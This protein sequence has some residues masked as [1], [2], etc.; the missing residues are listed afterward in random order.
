MLYYL[1]ISMGLGLIPK[2][3]VEM[4]T[5]LDHFGKAN[6]NHSVIK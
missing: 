5:V 3:R 6:Q 2:V 1:L 4:S